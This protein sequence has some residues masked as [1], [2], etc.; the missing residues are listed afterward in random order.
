MEQSQHEDT[1]SSGGALG[2]VVWKVMTIVAAVVASKVATTLASKTW[3]IVTGKPV[4][5]KSDYDKE[6]TRDVVAY[7][8][9]SAMFLTGAKV[10]AERRAAQY[11]RDSSGH[12]PKHLVETKPTKQEKKAQKRLEKAHKQES[13][14]QQ[15]ASSPAD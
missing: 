15:H 8:A 6:R 2:N 7:A 14:E 9:L 4:P 3:G 12:L 10:F 13:G 11:F 5:V 1:K